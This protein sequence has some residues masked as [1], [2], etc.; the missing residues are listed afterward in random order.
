MQTARQTSAARVSPESDSHSRTRSNLP[1]LILLTAF[2]LFL[3]GPARAGC[4]DHIGAAEKDAGIPSGLL[5]A[6]ALVESGNGGSPTP[7]VVNVKGKA[8]YA[9]TQAEAARFL[10]DG[11]GKLR[12][13]VTV[14]CMQLSLTHHR[15]AF[16]PVEKMLDPQENVR[17][18]ARY[19]ARLR[20]ETG[21]WAGAVARY[22]GGS[23]KMA[24]VYQCKVQRT[25]TELGADSVT[26]IDGSKCG[27]A[28]DPHISPKTRKA[29]EKSQVATS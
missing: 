27:K 14:G 23:V 29:F 3:A 28:Q 11:Q 24:K 2:A 1:F 13:N 5:M 22:N 21:S 19:L 26:L 20:S 17:Y 15:A 12:T 10:R 8:V 6:V 7:Y 18:A 9:R 25:L 16:R 4:L